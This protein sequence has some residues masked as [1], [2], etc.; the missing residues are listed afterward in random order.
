MSADLFSKQCSESIQGR[1]RNTHHWK[2]C[3]SIYW[4]GQEN[5]IKS[6]TIPALEEKIVAKNWKNSIQGT[7]ENG[8]QFPLR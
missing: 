8:M 5:F 3:N 7:I 6:N 1:Y 2:M 4:F